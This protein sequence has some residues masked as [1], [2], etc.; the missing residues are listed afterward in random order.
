VAVDAY[1]A[2]LVNL[3]AADVL[4]IAKSVEWGLGR[5]DLAKLAIKE[6]AA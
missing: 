1:G 5:M 3:K 4:M 2:P 6:I